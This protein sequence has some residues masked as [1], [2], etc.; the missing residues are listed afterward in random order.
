VTAIV[1]AFA[2]IKQHRPNADIDEQRDRPRLNRTAIMS[3][4]ID[5]EAIRNLRRAP[6]LQ[7]SRGRVQLRG[8]RRI[9]SL[10]MVP[11]NEPGDHF[12]GRA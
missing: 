4:V 9:L 7:T 8:R 12:Q 5:Q 11:T 6:Q 10:A 3:T 1:I 2:T